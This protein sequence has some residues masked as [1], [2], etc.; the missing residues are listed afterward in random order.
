MDKVASKKWLKRAKDDLNWTNANIREGI[1][2]GACF[3]AEQVA[4]KSLKA[5]LISRGKSVVKIHDLN[6]L[7]AR[8]TEIDPSF[9]ELKEACAALTAYYVPSRYPDI[10]EF[11]QFSEEI[12]KEASD[13]AEEVFKFVE[14]DI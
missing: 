11:M 8:C 1:W 14:K 9:E 7:L 4:E 12:A 3:T 5:F 13:L 2:Y 10:S 6:A